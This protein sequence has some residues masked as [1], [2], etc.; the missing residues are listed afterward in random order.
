VK[1]FDDR[2]NDPQWIT[3]SML[4]FLTSQRYN[5]LTSFPFMALEKTR[6]KFLVIGDGAVGKTSLLTTYTTHVFP[7]EYIPTVWD[8]FRKNL[9]VDDASIN[10]D[11][12]DT[13]SQEDYVNS[14]L[15]LSFPGTD[16]FL[17][18]F[19]L[20]RPSSLENVRERW[21]PILKR[22]CPTLPYILVGLQSDVR[23]AYLSEGSESRQTSWMNPI[24]TSAGKEMQ[25]QI[26]AQ[27][28]G[29]CSSMTY[30]CVDE[31]F[32]EGIRIVL[33][34]QEQSGGK[35]EEQ[36]QHCCSVG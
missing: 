7:G 31:I 11:L 17:I 23:E 20:V 9:T 10:L 25:R 15:H 34:R 29:E 13:S 8:T 26:G 1:S 28:Y 14:L 3:L 30:D 22:H 2:K 24:S 33:D 19:C 6:T 16:L 27:F 4:H 36:S 12:W 21:I 18:C 32:E 35:N 5:L